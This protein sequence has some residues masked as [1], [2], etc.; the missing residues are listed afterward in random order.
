MARNAEKI[1]VPYQATVLDTGEEVVVT[2]GNAIKYI[3][4]YDSARSYLERIS[5]KMTGLRNT[6]SLI[7]SVAML[8]GSGF[9]AEG[10]VN[11]KPADVLAGLAVA[12]ISY[13]VAGEKA[14]IHDLHAGNAEAGL[15]DLGI[16]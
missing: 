4:D 1:S 13:Y 10:I 6:F 16:I 3:G 12:G 5:D 8:I 11:N 9:A 14:K 15:E 2:R 7:K